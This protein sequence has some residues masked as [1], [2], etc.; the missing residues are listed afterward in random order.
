MTV[1]TKEMNPFELDTSEWKFFLLK[2]LCAIDMGNKLDFSAMSFD[3][4]TVNFVGRSAVDNGVM[5]KVDVVTDLNPY[6]AGA[7]TVA[8]GGSLG[9]T[10][11]QVEPFYTSQNVAVLQFDMEHV[12]IYARLF[13]ANM[14]HFESQFKY[15]PFGR[16][17]NKYL[18]RTYGF[19]L[20]VKKDA[21]GHPIIDPNSSYSPEGYVPDW[22]FMED[23]IKSLNHKPLTTKNPA[24]SGRSSD[25]RL[26]NWAWFSLGGPNGLFDIKKGKRLTAADQ[27]EGTTPYIGAIESNNGVS[28]RIGQAAIHD[29]NTIS[30]SYNGSVGEAFYQPDPYW[31]TDDVN[32]LYL[33]PEYGELTPAVGLF[34]STILRQ[35][36]YRFSYGRKWTLDNMN[37]T[38]VQLPVTPDGK[39]DWQFMEDYMRLLPYGDR[40]PEVGES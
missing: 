9:S 29:G 6:P 34:I 33:R 18:R 10:Y 12:S 32:A 8:L 28:N 26:D 22:Q 27:T 39:P 31:S 40:I 2:D 30:L 17:L 15:F 24:P 3:D 25:L 11:V 1:Q 35:E 20:P 37:A 13:L 19:K 4:P 16:E 23:F 5:G 14:I 38:S 7:L 21:A 36:K